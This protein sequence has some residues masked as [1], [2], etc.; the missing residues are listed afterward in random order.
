MPYPAFTPEQF[1]L[2]QRAAEKAVSLAE[3]ST[4]AGSENPELLR[5]RELAQAASLRWPAGSQDGPARDQAEARYAAAL[6]KF[7]RSTFQYF[8]CGT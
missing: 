5:D 8:R 6:I 2:V 7:G 3:N 1:A 4:A